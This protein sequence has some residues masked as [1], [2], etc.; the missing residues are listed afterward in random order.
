MVILKFLLLSL[1]AFAGGFEP[2]EIQRLEGHCL[3]ATGNE[4]Y[5]KTDDFRFSE[6]LD[7]ALMAQKF[8]R[9]YEEPKRLIHRV[10]FDPT[11]KKLFVRWTNGAKIEVDPL[12]IASVRNQIETALKRQYAQWIFF[13]DMGHSHFF[14]P[15]DR[16]DNFYKKLPTGDMTKYY[17][18]FMRDPTLRIF[19]HTAEQL[20]M[21]DE[22]KELV[23]DPLTRWR[24]YSRNI[25][26]FHA[27]VSKA[28]E[29][30][31]VSPP[32]KFNTVHDYENHRYWGAGFY[33]HSSKGACFAYQTPA[34]QTL[35]FDLNFAGMP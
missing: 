4:P 33:L 25:I 28:M 29:V 9:M 35:Y 31:Y 20:T 6:K 2:A 5:I 34:G 7:Q 18:E 3:E 19:Y 26:G 1:T 27:S 21:F 11:E 12:F 8:Q 16:W 10:Y 15:M 22:N 17:G 23:K 13:A 14:I 32:E 24:Y 30:L